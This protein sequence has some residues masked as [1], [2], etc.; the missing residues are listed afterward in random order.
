MAIIHATSENFQSVVLDSEKPVL[1]DFF[2]T[3]CGPCQMI[4]PLLEELAAEREDCA[5]VKVDVDEEPALAQAF[6]VVSIPTLFVVK[7]GEITARTV[8][9]APKEKLLEMLEG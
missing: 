8:G 7:G 2:A 1:L 6:G 9:Y 4:A 5:V 3:W